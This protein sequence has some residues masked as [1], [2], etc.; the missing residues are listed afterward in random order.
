[1]DF[2]ITPL[3]LRTVRPFKLEEVVLTEVAE[4]EG[5][6]LNDKMEIHKYLKEKVNSLIAAANHEFETRNADDEQ[7][8]PP[9]L[10]LIRLKVSNLLSAVN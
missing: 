6:D 10:P 1:M 7:D 5:L 3:I 4:E 9:M 8:T 2:Q